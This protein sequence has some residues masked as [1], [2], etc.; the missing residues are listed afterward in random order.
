MLQPYAG[1]AAICCGWL[2]YQEGKLEHESGNTLL[3]PWR[4]PMREFLP[5]IEALLEATD[6]RHFQNQIEK[7]KG[8][9][10]WDRETTDGI[11][12]L[13]FALR[14]AIESQ[15]SDRWLFFVPSERVNLYKQPLNGWDRAIATT[16]PDAAV[17]IEEA[18]RCLSFERGTAA[19]FHLM[20][21]V[22]DGL[23][24]IAKTLGVVLPKNR[25]LEIADQDKILRGIDAVIQQLSGGNQQAATVLSK[26]QIAWY[27]ETRLDLQAFKDAWR[28]HVSHSRVT[29]D[30]PTGTSI[31][32]HVR[33]FMNRMVQGPP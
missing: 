2:A 32:L 20:R 30:V 33:S 23:I 29:Y 31:Y 1:E 28:N 24:G 17:E 7:I 27:Q 18:G 10:D 6:M 21:A 8:Q 9:L 5:R 12:A 22:E 25:P 15:L 14:S 19:V 26:Q 11:R 4:V 3:K 16:Y 13:F